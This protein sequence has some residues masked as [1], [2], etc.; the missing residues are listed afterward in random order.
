MPGC[1]V[2]TLHTCSG[3]GG[4]DRTIKMSVA[5]LTCTFSEEDPA[6]VPSPDLGPH[7]EPVTVLGGGG[8]LR[9]V[10]RKGC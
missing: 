10:W 9:E 3:E 2:P 5:F 8:V 1:F 6:S 7:V 4:Q